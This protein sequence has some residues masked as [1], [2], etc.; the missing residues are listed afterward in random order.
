MGT[1]RTNSR[2][3]SNSRALAFG[4]SLSLTS[5][6][7]GAV[8][9]VFAFSAFALALAWPSQEP[10]GTPESRWR[11]MLQM[12][13]TLRKTCSSRPLPLP[14]LPLPPG[15][16]ASASA[17]HSALFAIPRADVTE[18]TGISL[19]T[20]A[21]TYFSSSGGTTAPLRTRTEAISKAFLSYARKDWH[22]LDK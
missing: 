12:I 3:E 13:S 9:A 22:S 17:W 2:C 8:L 18:L 15:C 11:R 21:V 19:G 16:V 6:T 5:A 7:F 14:P 4:S 20:G 1:W 10:H